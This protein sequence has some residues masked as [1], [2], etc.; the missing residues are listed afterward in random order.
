MLCQH[1]SETARELGFRMV[2]GEM[3]CYCP[4]SCWDRAS[5]QVGLTR[6]HIILY[7][8]KHRER[9]LHGLSLE[10][11]ELPE[12]SALAAA[13]RFLSVLAY[14]LTL[15]SGGH[16]ALIHPA[17]ASNTAPVERMKHPDVR[18]LGSPRPTAHKLRCLPRIRKAPCSISRF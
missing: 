12:P 11:S 16:L 14:S 7:R 5:L 17:V 15:G 8:T 18:A 9:D 6:T 2:C 3:T 10:R 4:F 13:A 1:S